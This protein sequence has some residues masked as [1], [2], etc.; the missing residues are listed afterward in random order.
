MGAHYERARDADHTLSKM[1]SQ[2]TQG[3][4]GPACKRA[5]TK[6]SFTAGVGPVSH[7]FSTS[8]AHHLPP[9]LLQLKLTSPLHQQLHNTLH[10]VPLSFIVPRKQGPTP[11]C[12]HDRLLA[13]LAAD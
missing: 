10:V 1:S 12:R 5:A 11:T 8:N 13:G 7:Y 9:C 6:A 4:V 3:E 2:V